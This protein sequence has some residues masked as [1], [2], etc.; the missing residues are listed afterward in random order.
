MS[1]KYIAQINNDNF[2]YPNN[3]LAEYDVE[4]IHNL[5]ENSVTAELYGV[6]IFYSGG[7]I[8]IRL[9]FAM[10]LNGAEPFISP[11]NGYLNYMS[12]HMMT[13]DKLYY[14]PWVCVDVQQDSDVNETVWSVTDYNLIVTPQ[15]AGVDAFVSGTYYLELR[16]LGKRCVFPINTF[17]YV[18]VTTPTPTP[19]TT[20][21]TP[22]PTPTNYC[23]CYQIHVT[24]STGT[25][26]YNDCYGNLQ[27]KGYIGAQTDHL[28]IEYFDGVVQYFTADGID[29]SYL[30]GSGDG[31]CR[32]GYVCGSS[33]ATPTPTPTATLIPPTNTPFPT[34]TPTPTPTIT[35]TP[36]PT[37][38]PTPTPTAT[39]IP[40]T[41]TL[42]PTPS[43]TPILNDILM[44][45]GNTVANACAS[46]SS[47]TYHYYGSFGIGTQLLL[48][49]LSDNVPNGSYYY[50]GT[51]LSYNVTASDGRISSTS[52][53]PTPT[54]TPTA[55][56]T[57][58]Y[59]SIGS[60]TS[61]NTITCTPSGNLHTVYLNS[62]DYATYSTNGNLLVTGMT[63]FSN[64]TGTLWSYTRIYDA[65]ATNIY[66][67]VSSVVGTVFSYC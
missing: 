37:F 11:V 59:T 41:P 12:V 50:N 31:N 49:D 19:T 16:F 3:R 67:V 60:Y 61:S 55:T 34:V 6:D 62:T 18:P 9:A 36:T 33:N 39:A 15:M 8:H 42:T 1:K 40:P 52:S 14:K 17:E 45:S 46:S 24:G 64:G 28:C 25:L 32:T 51:A 44:N 38:T 23:Y 4:I 48:P 57:V 56:P 7:N 2:V 5:Q 43:P 53:C 66:N 21:P 26:Q 65:N 20:G 22:T 35:N 13:P 27:T 58:S 47:A 29:T 30:T 63:L 10:Q 54:P